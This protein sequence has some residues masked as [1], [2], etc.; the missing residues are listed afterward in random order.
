MKRKKETNKNPHAIACGFLC[1]S[2]AELGRIDFNAGA[3]GRSQDAALDI[4]TLGKG[5]SGAAIQNMNL[6]LGCAEDEGLV[7]S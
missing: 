3:H 7:I 2:S 4:L 6:V 1:K 5:A